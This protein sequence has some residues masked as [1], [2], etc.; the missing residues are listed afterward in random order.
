[1]SSQIGLSTL[2]SASGRYLATILKYKYQKLKY[3]KRAFTQSF[4]W[5]WGKTN[6]NRIALVN[7]L[8]SKKQ[9]P[10]YLEIGCQSNTLLI[11]YPPI[12]KQ[13]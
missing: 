10:A 7:L 12:S 8:V 4:D 13:G 5:G 2:V 1:M 9:N 6:Y 11:P 3:Q